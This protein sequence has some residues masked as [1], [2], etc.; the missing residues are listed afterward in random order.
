MTAEIQSKKQE[1]EQ[2]ASKSQQMVNGLERSLQIEYQKEKEYIAR[3]ATFEKQIADLNKQHSK[4]KA[5]L[6]EDAK[7]EV[8][9]EK[10]RQKETFELNAKQREE[11]AHRETLAKISQKDNELDKK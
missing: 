8:Y 9:E 5:Q 10:Q 11:V 3:Q 7:K 4:E 6:A 1:N 2:L